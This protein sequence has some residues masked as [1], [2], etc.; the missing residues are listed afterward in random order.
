MTNNLTFYRKGYILFY[1]GG[2]ED[3]QK[4]RL[5]EEETKKIA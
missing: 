2:T 3:V 5:P 1:G 4:M